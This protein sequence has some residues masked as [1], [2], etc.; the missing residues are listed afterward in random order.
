MLSVILL[1]V[2]MPCS[3][4]YAE[5]CIA[6]CYFAIILSVVIFQ[7]VTMVNIILL[8]VVMPS[9]IMKRSVLLSA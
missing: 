4:H 8:S 2:V 9:F 3:C 5:F 7:S 6:E 1:R